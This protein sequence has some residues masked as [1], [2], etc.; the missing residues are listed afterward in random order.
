[1]KNDVT[2]CIVTFNSSHILPDCI[3]QIYNKFPIII[4]DNNSTDATTTL[5]ETKFPKILLIK[6]QRNLGYGRGNNLAFAQ[7][8]TK[9]AL[10]L[11]PDIIGADQDK[12]N[13]L[14][15]IA[16]KHQDAAFITPYLFPPQGKISD[17]IIYYNDVIAHIDKN[18]KS[19]NWAVG[20][21]L[22]VNMTIIKKIGMFDNNIFMFGE[23]NDLCDRAINHNYQIL[24]VNNINMIH[25]PGTSSGTNWKITYLRFWHVGWSKLYIRKKNKG[26]L[27]AILA[28]PRYLLSYIRQIITA[29]IKLDF[30]L[31]LVNIAKIMRTIRFSLGYKAFD[32]ND[33]PRGI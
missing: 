20:C 17:K 32:K 14:I 3:K 18:I 11:N 25:H 28:V 1:M 16:K 4:V 8:K 5:I 23:E 33:N 29:L 31:I 19:V 10:I 6:S 21:A 22:L 26:L 12:I 15:T 24:Q 30:N 2:I 27:K 13:H 7:V 9:Y